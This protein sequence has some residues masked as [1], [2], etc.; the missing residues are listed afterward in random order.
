MRTTIGEGQ[1][2][3]VGMEEERKRDR[4]G[5]QSKH[6]S[7]RSLAPGGRRKKNREKRNKEKRREEQNS[8]KANIK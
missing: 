5:R 8:E 4:E 3:T 2:K 1:N 7:S 6:W